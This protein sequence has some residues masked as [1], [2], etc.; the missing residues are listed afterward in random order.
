MKITRLTSIEV[1]NACALPFDKRKEYLLSI[2]K[3]KVYW[4]YSPVIA[5]LPK[6]LFAE[7]ELFGDLPLGD[8]KSLLDQIG[9]TCTS[10]A[11]QRNACVEVSRAIL[12]WAET[13]EIK[14]RIY[15]HEPLRLSVD[16]LR[17]C[18]DLALIRDGQLFVISLDPR[19]SLTL[20]VG[21]K[22]FIKSLIHHTALLGDLRS[23]KAAL[24]RTPS[25]GKG[26]RKAVFEELNGTP[27]L[28]LEEILE[29]VNQT[30]SIWEAILRS[31]AAAAAKEA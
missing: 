3:S 27:N 21:G 26:Q 1:A 14:S 16:T 30:Y 24:L 4:G 11:K 23:A 12:E 2:E 17:Y 18:A 25:I 29:R 20:T 22:E 28:D 9:K 15:H 10:G 31:R 6:L 8:K 7:A 13:N 19:S 5:A